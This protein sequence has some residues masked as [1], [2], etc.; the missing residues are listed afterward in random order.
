MKLT[1]SNTTVA[2]TL[3]SATKAKLIL[4]AAKEV[5]AAVGP[6]VAGMLKNGLSPRKA[7]ASALTQTRPAMKIIMTKP[8]AVAAAAKKTVAGKS[9]IW[10]SIILL[11]SKREVDWDGQSLEEGMKPLAE[12]KGTKYGTDWKWA[13]DLP[14]EECD[15]A[16]RLKNGRAYDFGGPTALQDLFNLARKSGA[17]KTT[18]AAGDNKLPKTLQLLKTLNASQF[19]AEWDKEADTVRVWATGTQRPMQFRIIGQLDKAIKEDTGAKSVLV[20]S[21]TSYKPNSLAL[22]GKLNS[23][24]A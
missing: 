2:A 18:K 16:I 9:S 23:K 7:H 15:I 3:D 22:N 10:G 14:P 5:K 20:L 8:V 19:G 17:V 13:G 12:M 6:K 1:L 11:P 4:E 21:G 24:P